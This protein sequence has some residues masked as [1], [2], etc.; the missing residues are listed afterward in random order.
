LRNYLKSFILF[1]DRSNFRWIITTLFFVLG[2][3]TKHGV[4]YVYYDHGWIHSFA[5]AKTVEPSPRLRGYHIEE[6][7][8]KDLW[9]LLYNPKKGDVIFDIGAGIG[10][11]TVFFSKKIGKFGRLFSVEAHPVIFQYLKKTIKLN[12]FR[13]T[14]PINLALCN[15]E[16]KILIDNNIEEYL[17]NTIFSK[18]SGIK[19]KAST[20]LSISEKYKIKKID[21][22]K[23]NIEDA[24]VLALLGM[25]NLITKT[26]FVCI[27]CHDF[28]YYRTE[29]IFYRT[30][31]KVIN[32][33]K[34]N[35]FTIIE[36]IESVDQ[37]IKDQINAYNNKLVK[38]ITK[39]QIYL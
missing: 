34:K 14:I 5:N 33:L 23:M 27:S 39:R 20:I 1:F 19:V 31:K 2:R 22:L 29:N 11:E 7:H 12:N 13:Q 37:A 4:K 30:K 24:E 32:L 6:K 28:K 10:S 16:G 17:G 9:C 38:K 21:F 26:K 8:N 3:L 25:G 36:R 15:K 35:N 18:K